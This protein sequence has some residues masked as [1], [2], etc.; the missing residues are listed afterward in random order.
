MPLCVKNMK[1]IFRELRLHSSQFFESKQNSFQ[2]LSY[3]SNPIKSNHNVNLTC[4]YAHTID[5]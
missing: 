4:I 1:A 3:F 2:I 5:L